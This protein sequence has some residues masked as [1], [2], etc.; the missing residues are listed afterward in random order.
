MSSTHLEQR[1]KLE[2]WGSIKHIEALNSMDSCGKL[3]QMRKDID[4]LGKFDKSEQHWDEDR[5][6]WI[7]S[8]K[9]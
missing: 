8:N 7:N 1:N 3:G 2:Q 6:M 5:S 9:F 4:A